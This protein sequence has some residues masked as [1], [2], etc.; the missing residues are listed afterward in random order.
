M[1]KPTLR[2]SL[3]SIKVKKIVNGKRI[4][5]FVHLKVYFDKLDEFFKITEI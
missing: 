2:Y 4:R 1:K 5:Q 3:I